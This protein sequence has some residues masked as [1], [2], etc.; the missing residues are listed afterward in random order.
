METQPK[1]DKNTQSQKRIQPNNLGATRTSS[2]VSDAL[3]HPDAAPLQEIPKDDSLEVALS[4]IENLIGNGNYGAALREIGGVKIGDMPLAGEYA[5]ILQDKAARAQIGIAERYFVRG[6][7][8]N[9]KRFYQ[10]AIE[11][12][13]TDP[14]VKG[15]AEMAS[16][17]FDTLLQ[18]RTAL[19]QG[20]QESI[21]EDKFDQW[22]GHKRDLSNLTVL[23]DAQIRSKVAPD[24]YLER[25]FGERPPISPSPGYID[26]L[27][28]MTDFIDFPSSMPGSVFRTAAQQIGQ[29]PLDSDTRLRASVAM[30][31]VASVMQVK[32]GLFALDSGLNVTG[33]ASGTVPLFRYE[34]LR[35]KAKRTIAHIQQIESRMLPIQFELDDFAEVVDAIRRP[36][37]EQKAELE[38]IKQRIVE[39]IDALAAL[40][41]MEKVIAD[42]VALLKDAED[43]CD[44]DWFCWFVGIM[45]FA[46]AAFIAVA[47][48]LAASATAGLGAVL[49]LSL[50]TGIGANLYFF[51]GVATLTCENVK[52]Y[53]ARYDT[54]LSG[55]RQGIKEVEAELTYA[56]VRRDILIANINALAEELSE[57]YQSNAARVLDAK[58]LNLIQ[59]QYNGIRQSLLT[60]AQAVAK[61]AQDSFNFERDT[62]LNLIR[63][64]YLDK[65]RKDY[66]AAETL[67]RDLD[68]LDYVDITGR[69]QKAMQLSHTVS[70]RKHYPVSFMTLRL[71]G[72][73]RFTTELKEFDRWFPGTHQQRI[74]EIKVE[75]M[76]EGRSAPVR[77]YLSN[78]G[79]SMVRFQDSSNKYPVDNV[80]VF[81]EP[82]ADIAQ[83]CYKRLQRRRHVDT[84][85][86]PDFG[87]YLHEDRMKKL[88]DRER[89]FFENVGLESTWVIEF[90]PDQ[91]FDLSKITDLLIHFQYEALFDENLKRL[92]EKK[93]YSGR[94]EMSAIPIRQSLAD[95]GKTADFSGTVSFIVPVQRLEAPAIER[96]I[97]NVGFFIKSKQQP[98]L[99]GPAELEVSYDGAAPIHVVTN[100][101]GIVATATDHPE[102][103]GLAELEEMV[104]GKN[105][106]KSWTLKIDALPDGLSADAVDEVFLLLNYEYA[107]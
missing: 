29:N 8:A 35:D 25:V 87:S 77:G 80:H 37:N 95:S 98:H 31:L 48:I 104:L 69:T 59:A 72:G 96:Q 5:F 3:I 34:Y 10:Q 75:V 26:S 51:L 99:N 82:D 28:L 97:V 12:A 27:P 49:A 41:Q 89:N 88:Q 74:K 47:G 2:V 100:D 60:R 7:I 19:I 1:R 92:L 62:E 90:L 56:L 50:L 14:A 22:C 45:D 84:M 24:Y 64:A 33:Q 13:T 23:D 58:T 63:D 93:R 86:F 4:K 39:L 67:L 32:I 83:L 54:A 103:T 70:L 102:G 81:P 6:D 9:A 106:D 65:D 18:Q 101:V 68:G 71:T 43:E 36:M 11:V 105:I 57:V 94:R 78:D 55:L 107:S 46:M 30:P 73:A 44:C 53:V 61:M 91:P 85:A 17:V 20:L 66:S 52:D 76:I 15:V 40:T 38:A 16:K 79:V 21:R 42:T